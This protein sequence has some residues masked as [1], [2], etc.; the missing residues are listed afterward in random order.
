MFRLMA[1]LDGSN[2]F[3]CKMLILG[4]KEQH[5]VPQ[6]SETKVK[7]N[8]HH[9]SIL[10]ASNQLAEYVVIVT[11]Q[12]VI[13]Y[14]NRSLTFLQFKINSSSVLLTAQIAHRSNYWE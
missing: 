14:M 8:V 2:T 7:T 9:Y 6:T 11:Y 10:S 1:S 4:L 13:N 12:S 3:V 5:F